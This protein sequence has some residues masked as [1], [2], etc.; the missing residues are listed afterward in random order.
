MVKV[1]IKNAS[2]TFV[3]SDTSAVANVS[4]DI[5]DK[6]FLVILGPSGSGKSTLLLHT[7]YNAL[8]LILNNNKSRKLPKPFKNIK[9]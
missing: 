5:T 2:K 4:L 6:E 8:N 7:L 9:A 3:N 1:S